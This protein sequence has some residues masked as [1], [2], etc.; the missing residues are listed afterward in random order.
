MHL[1][2]CLDQASA[3]G[4]L[5]GELPGQSIRKGILR[6]LQRGALAQDFSSYFALALRASVPMLARRRPA[7]WETRPR[8]DRTRGSNLMSPYSINDPSTGSTALRK[9][10]LLRSR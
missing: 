10:A 8:A 6:P 9:L 7:A 4:S 2:Q 5:P 1:T 3:V